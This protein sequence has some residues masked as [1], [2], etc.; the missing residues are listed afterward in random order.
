MWANLNVVLG[1]HE[2]GVSAVAWSADGRVVSGGSDGKLLLWDAAAPG[3]PAT[4]LGRHEG[5]VG[6]VAWSADGRVASGG[7][8]GKVLLW[9]EPP[10]FKEMVENVR[11]RLIWPDLTDEE[12]ALAGIE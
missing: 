8:D 6:A 5:F 9:G 1:R 7:G 11:A 12:N 4:E 2:G 3:K 10:S